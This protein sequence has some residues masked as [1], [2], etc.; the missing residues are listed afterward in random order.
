MDEAQAMMKKVTHG[1]VRVADITDEEFDHY[2]ETGECDER[3]CHDYAPEFVARILEAADAPS[4]SYK[5][6][7]FLV[8]IRQIEAKRQQ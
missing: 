3:F 4:K 6:D 2:R 8:L 1:G 7:E 5:A